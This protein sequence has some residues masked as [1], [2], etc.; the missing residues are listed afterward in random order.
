MLPLPDSLSRRLIHLVQDLRPAPA[1]VTLRE[2]LRIMGGTAIAI[3]LAA[4]LSQWVA[5]DQLEM[6]WHGASLGASALLIFAMPSSPIAQPWSVLVGNIASAACGMTVS[7]LVDNI[8]LAAALAVPLAILLMIQLRAVH[9][10]GAAISLYMVLNHIQQP[11]L[12]LFPL[13]FNLLLLVLV[14]TAYNR[15]T[16]RR[17]PHRQVVS[18]PSPA[19]RGHISQADVDA[20]LAR[21]NEVL[22]ISRED[23]TELLHTASGA[24]FQRHLGDL[25]CGDAMR[26]PVDS[27]PADL[28]LSQL[29]SLLASSQHR[30]LPVVDAENRLLG[31]VG[32]KEWMATLAPA[33]TSAGKALAAPMQASA[34]APAAARSK[35]L[36]FMDAGKWLGARGGSARRPL[37]DTPQARTVRD[38][39][40]PSL[41]IAHASQPLLEIVPVLS[42]GGRYH[43]PVVD[44]QHH[45]L[46][47]ITQ[48]DLLR[49]LDA[50]LPEAAPAS[51]S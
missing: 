38:V 12:L 26:T 48:T 3:A 6:F 25:T 19:A 28:P 2:C 27:V 16:G 21:Y 41:V 17:Y 37:R 39:M 14:G 15:A 7:I 40:V 32:L 29:H 5:H 47:I 18:E 4:F 46:G 10:P 34:R 1:N 49:A 11:S 44:A 30:E 45:L 23:L 36:G 33:A 20:A 50:A 13:G 31:S 51:M 8:V 42:Q 43:V 35:W 24:A 22:A 9:P